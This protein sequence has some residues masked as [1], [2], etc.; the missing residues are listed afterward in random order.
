MTSADIEGWDRAPKEHLS[1]NDIVAAIGCSVRWYQQLER[2]ADIDYDP[3]L[4]LRTAEAMRM[5]DS[6]YYYLHWCARGHSAPGRHPATATQ[7]DSLRRCISAMRWPAWVL[8]PSG[9]ILATNK[10]ATVWL[11]G[12]ESAGNLARWAMLNPASREQFLDWEDTWAPAWIAFLRMSVAMVAD[13]Q[14]LLALIAE[15]VAA[16]DLF[17]RLWHTHLIGRMQPVAYLHEQPLW[18][19]GRTGNHE[20]R[21]STLTPPGAW[22]RQIF[23]LQPVG[24]APTELK[25]RTSPT[26]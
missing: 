17:D 11:P 12:V 9:R 26:L 15:V 2:G 19:R 7:E 22:E 1:Q 20:M 16:D 18:I 6:E 14:D 3:A 10:A 4:L 23:M 24:T 25:A 5:T 8:T 13:D 21:L